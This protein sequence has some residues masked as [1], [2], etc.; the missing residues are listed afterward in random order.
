MS[1]VSEFTAVPDELVKRKGIL[2]ALIYGRVVR[3]QQESGWCKVGLDVL[4]KDCGADIKTVR[5]WLAYLTNPSDS[6]PY[7]EYRRGHGSPNQYRTTPTMYKQMFGGVNIRYDDILE[8]PPLS[9]G[10]DRVREYKRVKAHNR[11]AKNIG[12]SGD[13]TVSEWI[14]I[15]KEHKGKCAYCGGKAEALEHIVPIARG[16]STTAGNVVP[17]CMDCNSRKGARYECKTY[18]PSI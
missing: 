6:E 4:A 8:R 10:S 7:L 11:R 16:G 13:L 2:C 17:A 12:A 15:V 14:N 18:E 5:K 1:E 3:Y 9:L